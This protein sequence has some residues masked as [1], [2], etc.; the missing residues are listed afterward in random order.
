MTTDGDRMDEQRLSAQDGEC[1]DRYFQERCECDGSRTGDQSLGRL[2]GLLDQYPTCGCSSEL[3]RRTMTLICACRGGAA[4]SN[5][6]RRSGLNW[7]DE[8][9]PRRGFIPIP[10]FEILAAAACVGMVFILGAAM[11]PQARM[12]A[13]QQ[14]CRGN[15]RAASM[16]LGAYANDYDDSLPVF[17]NELPSG[18]WLKSQAGS[19]NLSVLAAANY[20][21]FSVLSCPS[22]T[23]SAGQAHS[24]AVSQNL[25]R[26]ESATYS[27]Q[28]VYGRA[29]S[30]LSQKQAFVVMG[31]RSP[32]VDAVT[33]ARSFSPECVGRGHGCDGQNVLVNDGSVQWLQ[34]ATFH[35]DNIWLPRGHTAAMLLGTETPADE[36]DTMLTH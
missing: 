7:E 20:A 1:I 25:P 21:S 24:A 9:A 10:L 12:S 16:G 5:E 11:I 32:V 26:A 19:A 14:M 22:N 2:M 8:T 23:R 15:L 3:T 13:Q 6:R 36:A 4:R 30:H 31:D 35:G 34:T 17:Y 28:N 18:N 27:Y 33:Q 29:R